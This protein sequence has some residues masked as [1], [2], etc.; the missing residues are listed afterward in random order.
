MWPSVEAAA[1]CSRFGATKSKPAPGPQ[2]SLRSSHTSR[3][4]QSSTPSPASH[5]STVSPETPSSRTVWG[6]VERTMAAY[7]RETVFY[8]PADSRPAR[9]CCGLRASHTIRTSAV[10]AP[11]SLPRKRESTRVD[12]I[13][14]SRH[15]EERS[16]EAISI[17]RRGDCFAT[18]AMTYTAPAFTGGDSLRC[19]VP[20]G[21][22]Y[23]GGS[24][25]LRACAGDLQCPGVLAGWGLARTVREGY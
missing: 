9:R 5:S 20:D 8:G 4:R 14:F 19:S 17:L 11:M 10:V 12:T 7:P 2:T 1:S 6:R 23:I 22:Q 3:V 15:C 16:D 25:S 21:D 18:L 24:Q 13:P